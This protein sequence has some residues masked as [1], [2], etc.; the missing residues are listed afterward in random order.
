MNINHCLI[1]LALIFSFSNCIYLSEEVFKDIQFM[2]PTKFAINY[3]NTTYFRYKL[4][5]KKEK[6]GLK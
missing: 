1:L 3:T 5:E 2:D 6:V 4:D